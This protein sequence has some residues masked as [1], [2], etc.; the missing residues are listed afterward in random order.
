[1]N[2]YDVIPSDVKKYYTEK[3]KELDICMVPGHYPVLKTK[4]EV[5]RWFGM[6]QTIVSKTKITDAERLVELVKDN[7][8]KMTK[9]QLEYSIRWFEHLEDRD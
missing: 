7:V 5:D 3:L 2:K 9:K 4:E 1:M 8:H 6:M